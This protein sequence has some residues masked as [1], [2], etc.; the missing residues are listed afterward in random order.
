MG[1]GDIGYRIW[2]MGYK[3]DQLTNHHVVR[4]ATIADLRHLELDKVPST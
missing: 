4:N 2:G 1:Y 3:R